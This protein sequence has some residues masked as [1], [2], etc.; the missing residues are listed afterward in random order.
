MK[1]IDQYLDQETL[2]NQDDLAMKQAMELLVSVTRNKTR[3]LSSEPVITHSIKVMELLQ[4]EGEVGDT[5][6]AALLHD[7]VEDCEPYGSITIAML[8]EQ[9][10]DR[11]AT[12]VDLVSEDK[13]LDSWIERKAS[14]RARLESGLAANPD[15][16]G[17]V[18][19]KLADALHNMLS[20]LDARR[21]LSPNEVQNRFNSTLA[22][23]KER[24]QS[25]LAFFQH[26]LLNYPLLVLYENTLVQYLKL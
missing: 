4:A 14:A 12:L 17:A 7:V 23:R 18:K 25:L 11:V 3:K 10:G 13:T 8:R 5:L 16:I 26:H 15:N 21:T 22:Q 1:L 20:E 19:I 24:F 9:F 2:S 6:I